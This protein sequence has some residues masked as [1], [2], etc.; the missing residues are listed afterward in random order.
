MA[1]SSVVLSADRRAGAH[2]TVVKFRQSMSAE[3]TDVEE[4]FNSKV[5]PKS[6]FTDSK[7]GQRVRIREHDSAGDD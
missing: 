2:L 5:L 6:Y 4:S 3:T 1:L 7:T